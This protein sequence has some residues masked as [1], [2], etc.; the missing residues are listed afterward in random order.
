VVGSAIV[1]SFDIGVRWDPLTGPTLQKV[2][3]HSSKG[4]EPVSKFQKV[5]NF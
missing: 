2:D 5:K 4:R 3:S 1:P